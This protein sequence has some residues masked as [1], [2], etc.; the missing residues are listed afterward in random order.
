M[1]GFADFNPAH[2]HWS[3]DGGIATIRLT[4][5]TARTR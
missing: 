5:R 1:T 2:F 3:L 4:G